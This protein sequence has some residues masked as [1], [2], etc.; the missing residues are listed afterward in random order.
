MSGD[1]RFFGAA[2]FTSDVKLYE[3]QYTR[4]GELRGVRKV[5]NLQKAHN[6]QVRIAVQGARTATLAQ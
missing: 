6:G 3:V 1:G 4:T 2:T 5:M